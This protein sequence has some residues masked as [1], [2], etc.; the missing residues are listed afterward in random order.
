MSFVLSKVAWF[1]LSPLSPIVLILALGFF[2][3]E[4]YP[5]FARTMVALALILLLAC[6]LPFLPRYCM[7]TLEGRVPAG[8]ITADIAGIIVL[9]GAIDVGISRHGRIELLSSADRIVDAVILAN[10]YPKAKLVLTG[11]SGSLDQSQDLREADYLRRLAIA[12]G[13]GAERIVVEREARITHEHPIYL[14]KLIDKKQ[15]WVLV[16]SAAHMPRAVG[17]FKKYGFNIIPCPVDYQVDPV[18]ADGVTFDD[19]VP[20][21]NNL[22]IITEAVHEWYGLVFY[23]LRG[24][25]DVLFP[26]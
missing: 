20:Q 6:T 4:R 9:G 14:A 22:V 24:Y 12:L 10:K 2:C 23:R 7:R 18:A 16:T 11:G 8:R 3:W 17:C 13:I 15:K 1:L 19:F 25:T 26:S 5:R 21:V